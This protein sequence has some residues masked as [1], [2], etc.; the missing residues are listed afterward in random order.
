MPTSVR[1][2]QRR[3]EARQKAARINQSLRPR[4]VSSC[5]SA[6]YGKI[7]ARRGEAPYHRL[8]NLCP[9]HPFAVRDVQT[10]RPSARSAISSTHPADPPSLATF[11]AA[12]PNINPDAR[13]EL[14][15]IARP[16]VARLETKCEGN[17]TPGSH[18]RIRR[19]I[20]DADLK[21]G[22]FSW[23][24][25]EVGTAVKSRPGLVSRL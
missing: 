14:D 20:Q 13:A 15:G 4:S 1:K 12:T 19:C 16:F 2:V 23:L 7:V 24:K 9:L 17:W 8:K 5:H 10:S 25:C 18:Q 22:K 11:P 21:A 6:R 3:R